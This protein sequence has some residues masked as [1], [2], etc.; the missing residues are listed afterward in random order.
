M[1]VAAAHDGEVLDALL[2][3]VVDRADEALVLATLAANRH[4]AILPAHL[5]GGTLVQVP[6]AAIAA[7]ASAPVVKLWD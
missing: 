6:E 7:P 5:P 1:T 4:L 2:L 3:R